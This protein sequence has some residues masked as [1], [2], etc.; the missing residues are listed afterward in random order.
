VTILFSEQMLG[1]KQ[2]ESKGVNM[3]TLNLIKDQVLN[4]TYFCNVMPDESKSKA[5]QKIPTIETWELLNFT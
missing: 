2:L 5:D 4:V 3:T 1:I